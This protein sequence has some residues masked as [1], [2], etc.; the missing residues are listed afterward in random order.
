MIPRPTYARFAQPFSAWSIA[1]AVVLFVTVLIAAVP[2]S[3]Q[4][5]FETS[6][7][8][9][10]LMDA[11]TGTV[12]FQHEADKPMPPASMAK[13]M[14]EAVVFDAIKS[15]R[16]SAESEFQISEDAWRRGGAPSRTSTMFANL[17]SSVKVIDLLRGMI[18]Q[19]ANDACIAIAEGMAGNEEAFAD[20]MNEEAEK[21]GLTGSLFTNATGLPD[22]KQYVSARDLAKLASH[23]ITD[24]PEFYPIY[25]EAEFTWNKI[26]QRNRNPLIEMNIGAD[27]LATGSTEESGFGLVGSAVRSGQRLIVV[28]NGVKSDKERA[29]EARKLIDWGFRAFSR[30]VLFEADEVVAEAKVFGGS[31][32]HVGLVGGKPIEMLLPRGGREQLKARVVYDGPVSAPV[33]KGQQIGVLRVQLGDDLTKET[34]LYAANYV[35]IGTIRQR[36]VDGIEELLI[37]WW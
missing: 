16:L 19:S 4:Q 1:P 20:L 2:A 34:P 11:E 36:A 31:Q 3:A 24:F 9:A 32:R 22:P 30:T 33:Q 27:G 25:R 14:T 6:A 35:G 12:L 37:G 26:T 28:I 13:L 17:G 21:L 5:R 7:T 8:N 18:V 10:L 15:G 29:E 23:I